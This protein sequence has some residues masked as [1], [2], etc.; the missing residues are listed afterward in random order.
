MKG[1]TDGCLL[2]PG[3]PRGLSSGASEPPGTLSSSLEQLVSPASSGLSQE[4]KYPVSQHCHFP[5]G[6]SPPLAP[7]FTHPRP[8]AGWDQGSYYICAHQGWDTPS[9]VLGPHAG[10]S[11][12]FEF[13]A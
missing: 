10:F 6:L 2:L 4:E 1:G 13:R 3:V 12:L 7:R 11:C 9:V 5:K 8:G